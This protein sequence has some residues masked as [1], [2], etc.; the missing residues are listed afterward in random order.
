MFW[1]VLK[2]EEIFFSRGLKH[3]IKHDPVKSEI[4]SA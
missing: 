1:K 4:V 3:N 2:G